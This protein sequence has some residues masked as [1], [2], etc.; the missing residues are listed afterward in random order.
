MYSVARSPPR[1]PGARPSSRSL[2]RNLTCARMRWPETSVICAQATI[3]A[4]GSR[5]N[6]FIGLVTESLFNLGEPDLAGQTEILAV[7]PG[8]QL[9]HGRDS[10]A[11]GVTGSNAVPFHNAMVAYGKPRA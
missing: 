4:N 5:K 1:E 9:G 8:R 2:A 11:A 10:L 6:S 7:F 3:A